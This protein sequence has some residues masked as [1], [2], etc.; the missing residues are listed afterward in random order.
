MTDDN[1]ELSPEK[2]REAQAEQIAQDMV[3]RMETHFVDVSEKEFAH[4]MW[5]VK[6]IVKARWQSALDDAEI[7]Y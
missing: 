5:T 3:V 2:K 7:A 6:Q 1:Y 4:L